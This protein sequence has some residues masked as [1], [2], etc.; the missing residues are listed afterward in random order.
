M[1]KK[2][3]GERVKDYERMRADISK[4]FKNELK[5]L[6]LEIIR[7]NK[8]N[9]DLQVENAILKKDIQKYKNRLESISDVKK[10]IFG[11]TEAIKH[12]I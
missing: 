2:A 5:N 10:D 6:K 4:R 8:E 3:L 1:Q 11:L 12:L 9:A 7:L